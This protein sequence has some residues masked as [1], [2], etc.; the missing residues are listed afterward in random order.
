MNYNKPH[1]CSSKSDD[2]WSLNYYLKGALSIAALTLNVK[3][4][5]TVSA[6]WAW[7]SRFFQPPYLIF[8]A[9]RSL[10]PES[11]MTDSGVKKN[12]KK[13]WCNRTSHYGKK[14]SCIT[15]FA[16][17]QIIAQTQHMHVCVFEIFSMSSGVIAI[18]TC[19]LTWHW[20][21]CVVIQYVGK[22]MTSCLV[23]TTCL[24]AIPGRQTSQESPFFFFALKRLWAVYT[25]ARFV[26]PNGPCIDWL[27]YPRKSQG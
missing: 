17:C 10:L 12:K 14:W 3:S 25:R 7:L 11:D 8:A 5:C 6:H 21:M 16:G 13:N 24:W 15:P 19:T 9:T 27:G 20:Q 2:F 1:F 22:K 4:W 26:K 23:Q 18:T